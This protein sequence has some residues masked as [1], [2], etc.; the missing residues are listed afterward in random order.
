MWSLVLEAPFIASPR[1]LPLLPPHIPTSTTTAVLR[2]KTGVKRIT[3]LWETC[4][5]KK[6][7]S[8]TMFDWT[9]QSAELGGRSR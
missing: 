7:G 2:L 4:D 9:P 6:S 8:S 3:S 5:Q 1:R